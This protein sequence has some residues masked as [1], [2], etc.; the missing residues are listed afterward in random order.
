MQLHSMSLLFWGV[1]QYWLVLSDISECAVSPIF[2]SQA[3]FL[4][5]LTNQCCVTCQKNKDNYTVE[6]ALS[7][8]I[9]RHFS[10]PPIKVCVK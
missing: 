4:N 8:S 7:I 2:E 9:Y 10:P 5:S 3:V 1:M 6:E